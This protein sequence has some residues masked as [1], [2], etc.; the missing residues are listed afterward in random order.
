MTRLSSPMQHQ[1][2]GTGLAWPSSRRLSKSITVKF[3]SRTSK[4]RRGHPHFAACLCGRRETRERHILVVDDEVGIR[5]LLSEILT[6]EGYDVA[7][8]GKRRG[9]A[10]LPCVA[11]PDLVLLDIWMPTPTA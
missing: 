6:D 1:G 7:P 11:S 2:Q 8:G 3:K 4:R 10:R 9:G 5:E